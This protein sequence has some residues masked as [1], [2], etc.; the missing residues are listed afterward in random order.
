MDIKQELDFYRREYYRVLDFLP[1]G[2]VVCANIRY[3]KS[4]DEE[5]YFELHYVNKFFSELTGYILDEISDSW[6][7]TLYPDAEYR[8]QRK[9]SAKKFQSDLNISREETIKIY[10]KNGDI[11]WFKAVY[12]GDKSRDIKHNLFYFIF[13][14]IDDFQRQINNLEIKSRLDYLTELPNRQGLLEILE[15]KL[16]SIKHTKKSF[17]VVMADI[18][19]FKKI[20]DQYAHSCGDFVL[21]KIAKK[22]K[23]NL[24]ESDLISR[25]GGEEFLIVFPSSNISTVKT[26][27]VRIQEYLKNNPINWQEVILSVTLTF[28]VAE[29]RENTSFMQICEEADNALYTGKRSG[30]NCIVVYE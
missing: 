13:F 9:E 10:C 3:D 21:Q 22:L 16:V 30:R 29:N 2:I 15:E 20:N 28:G 27:L 1:V 4:Q 7:T 8:S 6:F 24:R 17:I 14:P 11:K 5:V 19:N 23:K 18:D 26:I 12:E 25:W